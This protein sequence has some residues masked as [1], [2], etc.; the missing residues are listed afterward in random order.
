MTASFKSF[1][2]ICSF[3]FFPLFSPLNISPYAIL[4]E[5]HAKYS[6]PYIH[7]LYFQLVSSVHPTPSRS[8]KAKIKYICLQLPECFSMLADIIFTWFEENIALQNIAFD[9]ITISNAQW[10]FVYGYRSIFIR[11][12]VAAEHQAFCSLNAGKDIFF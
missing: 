1:I 7:R 12:V 6:V 9:C 11:I 4:T 3:P 2:K 8:K 5:K 10:P